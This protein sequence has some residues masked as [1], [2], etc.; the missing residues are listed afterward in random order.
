MCKIFTII[1][2]KETFHKLA[3]LLYYEYEHASSGGRGQ[4]GVAM[5]EERDC[6]GQS[7]HV[8]AKFISERK[9]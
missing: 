8:H 1:I 9:K 5:C 3:Y 7:G 6:L 4:R 2:T